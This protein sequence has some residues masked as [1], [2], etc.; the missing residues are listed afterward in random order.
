MSPRTGRPT[1]NPKGERLSIRI[2][3]ECSEILTEYCQK[4]NVNKGEAVREG[5]KRLKD[6]EKNNVNCHRPKLQFTLFATDKKS[7]PKFIIH[8]KALFVKTRNK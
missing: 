7:V 5:I 6:Y 4:N 8:W 1:D 2:D 3:N